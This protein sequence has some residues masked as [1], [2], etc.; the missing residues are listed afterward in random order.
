MPSLILL[1]GIWQLGGGMGGISR[2]RYPAVVTAEIGAGDNVTGSGPGANLDAV[3]G[4]YSGL[5]F[6]TDVSIVLNGQT[7]HLGNSVLDNCDVYPGDIQ[8]TGDLKFKK[9]LH[10]GLTPDVILMEIFRPL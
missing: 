2:T 10:G 8:T 7:L 1:N 5:G 6:T 4:D 9:Q 3:L